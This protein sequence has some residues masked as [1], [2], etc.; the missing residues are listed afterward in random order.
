MRTWDVYMVEDF[1][2]G[3]C[4]TQLAPWMR[5]QLHEDV[6]LDYRVIKETVIAR[7]PFSVLTLD[8][9]MQIG[10][11]P[12]VWVSLRSRREDV[13]PPG[14]VPA[15]RIRPADIGEVTLLCSSTFQLG[16]H[17]KTLCVLIAGGTTLRGLDQGF[18]FAKV[19]M[20]ALVT[21]R[22][23]EPHPYSRYQ[24]INDA[25]LGDS[26]LSSNYEL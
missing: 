14:L 25:Q 24:I 1:V 8:L 19:L 13:L 7:C 3:A 2:N 26:E 11:R 9:L 16:V 5:L 22:P 17:K 6:G 20:P 23:L 15:I 10:V 21:R 12:P 4:L 18:L